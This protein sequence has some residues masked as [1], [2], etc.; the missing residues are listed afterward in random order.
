MIKKFGIL[1]ICSFLIVACGNSKKNQSMELLGEACSAIVADDL[2]I[3]GDLGRGDSLGSKSEPWITITNK[4]N[5]AKEL[6]PDDEAIG[7][8][9]DQY[10][11]IINTFDQMAESGEI[12]LML[13][14]TPKLDSNLSSVKNW[15]GKKFNIESK[16]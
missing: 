11:E 15:C 9:Y 1:F 3:M 10:I 4:F 7:L 2:R 13:A 12:L 6:Q 5:R 14:L 8:I 16:K